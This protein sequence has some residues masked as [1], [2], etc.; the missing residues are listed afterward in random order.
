MED[1]KTSCQNN[2]GGLSR[3]EFPKLKPAQFK[4]G[5]R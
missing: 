1:D 5:E 4:S 2:K 3:W